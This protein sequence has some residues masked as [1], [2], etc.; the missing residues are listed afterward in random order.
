M[1]SN[2]VFD[3]DGTIANSK[4]AL[5]GVYNQVAEKHRFKPMAEEDIPVLSR[6]SIPE[7]CS[8]MGV[9]LY[10]VPSLMVEVARSYR[11]V[12]DSVRAFDG[13]LSV[14]QTLHRHGLTVGI[15]SSNATEN[16]QRFLA[17]N[18]MESVVRRVHCSSNLFGKDKVI[19]RYLKTYGLT[20]EQ[21]VY[22]GDEERDV[23]ACK[24]TKLRVLSVSWG[25]DSLDV[26][27]RVNP[28]SIAHQPTDILQWVARLN[29]LPHL[30]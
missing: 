24:K 30:A 9:P 25:L 14:L 19:S 28:D 27:T 20:S 4:S 3:F 15:I 12:V 22:V 23:V 29:G 10:K 21:V 26:L 11:N 18:G 16:I 5:L 17:K 6:L 8:K 13:M 1:I 7:R 2:V